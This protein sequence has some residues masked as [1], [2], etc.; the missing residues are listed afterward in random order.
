MIEM[1]PNDENGDVLRKMLESGDD[2]ARPREIDFTVVM[3]GEAAARAFAE[4]FATAGYQTKIKRSGVVP[5]QPWD[6]VVIKHMTPNHSEI[7][8][9][10]A[11]LEQAALP[12]GGRN[13]GWGCFEQSP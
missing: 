10:E 2:L 6:V 9:F 5:E 13:D 12:L 4:R 8:E 1:I 3:P 11:L 7:T